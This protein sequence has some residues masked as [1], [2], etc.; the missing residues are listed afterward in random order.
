VWSGRAHLK[1]TL[2]IDLNSSDALTVLKMLHRAFLSTIISCYISFSNSGTL[3]STP[4][5]KI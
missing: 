5:T 2:N 3:S 1:E 4:F